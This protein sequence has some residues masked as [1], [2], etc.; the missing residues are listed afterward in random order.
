MTE[1]QAHNPREAMEI[2]LLHKLPYPTHESNNVFNHSNFQGFNSNDSLSV[3]GLS[4]AGSPSP[5]N[6]PNA[7]FFTCA[8]CVHPNGTLIA[9]NGQV[10]TLAM[11]QNGKLSPDLLNPL[12]G[13]TGASIGDPATDDSPRQFQFSFH[14]RF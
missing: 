7:N 14:V 10:L 11:L 13:S 12:F 5:T 4:L 6:K 9:T 1:Y 3:V 2:W 8:N